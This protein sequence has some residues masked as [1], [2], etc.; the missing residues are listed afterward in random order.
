LSV[1]IRSV[2]AMS[3]ERE[4]SETAAPADDRA[5]WHLHDRVFRQQLGNS[6]VDLASVLRSV[7]PPRLVPLLALEG[8]K[9][10]DGTFIDDE[11]RERQ[12]DVLLRTRLDGRTGFVYVLVEH[13]STPDPLMAYR[14]HRYMGRIWERYLREHPK[15]TRLPVIL[16]VVIYQG[17]RPWAAPVEL[18]DVLDVD[19]HLAEAA[20]EFLPRQR[21]LL[22]DLT[23]VDT[24]ALRTWS[25]TPPA[26][27]TLVVLKIAPDNPGV[28]E[29]LWEWMDDLLALAR[30]H[31][32]KERLG[33]LFTYSLGA[34]KAPLET[35][36][37]IAARLGREAEEALMTTAQDLRAEG[38]ANVLVRQL[39]R[40]F[41]PLPEP[42]EAAIRAASFEQLEVWTD[43]VLVAASLDE[44]LG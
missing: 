43:R 16:P 19:P 17:P 28:A 5:V 40:K 41:G 38:E 7:L 14:V 13:Q 22:E 2:R 34:S 39:T 25:L 24:S 6:P 31:D 18:R 29:D 37:P 20:A 9:V 36:R 27:M 42:T 1:V 12:C 26:R 23:Q 30:R 21:F 35:L 44:V 3:G 4:Q 10:V 32:G 11:L 33:G 8:S 15:A